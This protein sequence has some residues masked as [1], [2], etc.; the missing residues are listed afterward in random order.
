VPYEGIVK[1][2]DEENKWYKVKY[3]DVDSEDMTKEEVIT[4]I[5]QNKRVRRG[6]IRKKILGQR[7]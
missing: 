4:Y 5:K 7:T 6:R 3:E 2:Y 1:E